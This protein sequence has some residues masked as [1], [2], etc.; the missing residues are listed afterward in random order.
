V[1]EEAYRHRPPSDWSATIL[2]AEASAPY[3]RI[4]LSRALA[5]GDDRDL[6]LKDASWYRERGVRIALA[7]PAAVVDTADKHVICESGERIAYDKLVIATGSSVASPPILGLD[8]RGVVRLR[9]DEDAREIRERVDAGATVAIVGGGLVGL[10]AAAALVE[11]GAFV[12]VVHGANRLMDRQLDGGSA[13]WLRRQL[14]A[15]G[16]K[17]RVGSFADELLA[18]EGRVVGVKLKNGDVVPADLVILAT[19]VSP[20]I[21]VAA[22]AGIRTERG[23]VVDDQMRTSAPDVW[24]LGECAQHEG[25]V[26]GTWAP[27]SEQAR[28]LAADLSGRPAGFRGR[29]QPTKLKVPGVNVFSCGDPTRT[30]IGD[31]DIDEVVAIDSRAGTYR[32]LI[33]DGRDLLGAVLMGDISLAGQLT[34]LLEEGGALQDDVLDGLL[35]S[36]PSDPRLELVCSCKNVQAGAIADA[37][38]AGARTLDAVR[39]C[40]GA[41]TG[42]GSCTSRVEQLVV[43]HRAPTPAALAVDAG[44]A[45]TVTSP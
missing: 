31:A 22:R 2:C 16:I 12:T 9:T 44:A 13:K 45:A 10:E 42:C 43:E 7:T 8:L 17:S 27:I 30:E 28:V 23:I 35:S 33:F 1:L 19:G 25:T 6:S 11:R 34:A 26:Y 18:H 41:S 36:A 37:V 5:P 24:A 40:T 15:R 38:A 14:D 21:S 29:P 32:R 4:A 20:R 39:D 3:D